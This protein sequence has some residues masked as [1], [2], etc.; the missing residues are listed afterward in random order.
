MIGIMIFT[1]TAFVMSLLIVAVSSKFE[2]IDIENKYEDLLPGYNCGA[3]GFNTCLGMAE[4]M[5]NDPLNYKK[6]RPL[7]GDK[8]LEMEAYL[9]I[10]K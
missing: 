1:I 2:V 9:K 6:C 5:V 4:A 8:L 3:C 7:R 10:K